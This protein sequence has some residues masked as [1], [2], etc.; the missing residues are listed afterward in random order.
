VAAPPTRPALRERYDRRRQE[1]VDT[2][3]ELFA[4]RGYV[5]T[6]ISD[7]SEATGIKTGGLYHYIGSKE[8][9]LI[10]ILDDLLEPILRR[11]E[12]IAADGDEAEAQLRTFVRAWMEHN[13]EHRAHMLVFNQERH[14]IEREPQ[15]RRIRGSRKRFEAV[16]DG[17]LARCERDAGLHF[18]DRRVTL[19]ALL[20]M[21]NS[22]P[23]WFDADGRLTPGEIA[24]GFCDLVL[25]GG[26]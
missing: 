24:D 6:S 23:L 8:Q 13:A 12:E 11:V 20:G 3:A 7:L 25:A 1:V 16:L 9:L 21:V 4:E 18:P 15:W 19:M 17:I 5:D 2:A 10:Q 14:V 26:R 22:T